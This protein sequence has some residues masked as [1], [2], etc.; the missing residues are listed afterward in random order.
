[1]SEEITPLWEDNEIG[2]WVKANE[3]A[4]DSRFEAAFFA[5]KHTKQ[6]YE[7][8]R[9]TLLVRIAELEQ[10]LTEAR[11]RQSGTDAAWDDIESLMFGDDSET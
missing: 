2:R 5:A 6:M 3:L 11:V 4:W 8:E 7:T 10:Q 1:M 9:A